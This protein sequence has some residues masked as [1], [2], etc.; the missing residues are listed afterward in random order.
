MKKTI[1]VSLFQ[2]YDKFW[3]IS[4]N[5]FVFLI[6]GCNRK[7]YE[8]QIQFRNMKTKYLLHLMFDMMFKFTIFASVDNFCNL[9]GERK[10]FVSGKWYHVFWEKKV[11]LEKKKMK[12]SMI[13]RRQWCIKSRNNFFL[14]NC[15]TLLWS[16]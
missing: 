13:P 12:A 8:V 9:S 2:K 5:T 16:F 14:G 1:W 11:F 6:N 4:Q 15:L 10:I 7:T 3:S